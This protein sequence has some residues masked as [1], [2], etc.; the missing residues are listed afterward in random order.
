M[1]VMLAASCSGD[2]RYVNNDADYE[3]NVP[4]GWHVFPNADYKSVTFKKHNSNVY[5]NSIISVKVDGARFDM[6]P[7]SLLEDEILPSFLNTSA[8]GGITMKVVEEPKSVD[9]NKRQW[10]TAKCFDGNDKVW[11][12]YVT[13]T[14]RYSFAI[15]LLSIGKQNSKDERLFLSSLKSLIIH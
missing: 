9:L 12:A 2:K 4:P 6:T 13:F 5:D 14:D 15:V 8:D 1:F 10:V 3:I 7:S 11:Q